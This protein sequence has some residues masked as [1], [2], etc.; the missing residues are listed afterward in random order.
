MTEEEKETVTYT[1]PKDE[2]KVDKRRF[3]G[4]LGL[5]STVMMIGLISFFSIGMVGA[6]LGVGIGGF[7]AD[8][9]KVNYNDT[10]VGSTANAQIYPVL[11]TQAAC[12]NAPQIEA[13]LEGTA[14]LA[15]N[16]SFFKDLPLPSTNFTTARM[17]RVGIVASSGANPIQATDLD[18]RLSAL[19]AQSLEL[20]DADIKEFGPS[21]YD[22]AGNAEDSY[23]PSGAG[24]LDGTGNT[25]ETP[26]FG[27]DARNFSVTNG[28]AATHQVS[29]SSISL[30]NLDLFVAID[31]KSDFGGGT[32]PGPV[33]RVVEP[34]N[35][36]C[37][38]LAQV[39]SSDNIN[40][41][42]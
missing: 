30:S 27:I 16:V 25:T 28:V 18:L 42:N 31:D 36:T 40:D 39:S 1:R 4:I 2:G 10:T 15:G 3:A 34:S 21:S 26:E 33:E 12:E 13:S 8:F 11:G 29:L 24:V 35:R 32:G 22:V 19:E 20:T 23:A 9:E 7:V 17:A 37:A 14:E 5:A 38:S 6:A 41:L